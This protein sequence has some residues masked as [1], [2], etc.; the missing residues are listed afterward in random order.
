MMCGSDSVCLKTC[1]VWDEKQV[2]REWANAILVPIPK[3]G[4]LSNCDNWR[5]IALLNV[6]GNAVA[7]ILQERLQQL[8]EEDLLVS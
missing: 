7:S 1:T 3:K 4:N 6:V 5:G 8:A 2:P